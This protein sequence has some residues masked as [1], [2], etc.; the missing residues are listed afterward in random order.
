MCIAIPGR[1]LEASGP[2]AKVD[3]FGTVREV[4]SVFVEVKQDDYILAF[5]GNIIEKVTKERA[6]ELAKLF[7][8]KVEES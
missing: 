3:F 6:V 2:S 5:N 1:V 8:G 4:N 7:G